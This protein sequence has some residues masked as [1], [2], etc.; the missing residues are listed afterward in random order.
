MKKMIKVTYNNDP[1]KYIYLPEMGGK[2]IPTG[3]EEKYIGECKEVLKDIAAEE[4]FERDL[5]A[6]RK[7]QE[8]IALIGGKRP[9]EIQT[10]LNA[11]ADHEKYR[12]IMLLLRKKPTP[13]IDPKSYMWMD[14]RKGKKDA[15]IDLI[16]TLQ[17]KGYFH[18]ALTNNEI[19]YILRNTFGITCSIDH[20]KHFTYKDHPGQLIAQNPYRINIPEADKYFSVV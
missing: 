13:I 19:R 20:I 6:R 1:N 10:L 5:I 3:C 7:L 11:F 8:E 15:A 18:R 14:N 17:S 4:C 9:P 16:F 2:L 12:R